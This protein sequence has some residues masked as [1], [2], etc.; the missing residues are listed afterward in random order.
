ME[1]SEKL[2]FL[3]YFTIYIV[4]EKSLLSTFV[5]SIDSNKDQILK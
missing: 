2:V 1:G 4:L 5:D 3:S